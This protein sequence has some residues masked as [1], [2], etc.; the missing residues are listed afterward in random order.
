MLYVLLL[1][2]WPLAVS[3]AP[4]VNPSRRASA[5]HYAAAVAAAGKATEAQPSVPWPSHAPQWL[6][7]YVA[8]EFRDVTEVTAS[9]KRLA[10]I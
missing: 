9:W 6:L 5:S 10:C 1:A 4:S 7:A 3:Q 8:L 2:A